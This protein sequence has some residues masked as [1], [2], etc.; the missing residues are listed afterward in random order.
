[1]ESLPFMDGVNSILKDRESW[2]NNSKYNSDH[3][4]TLF[5]VTME[6]SLSLFLGVKNQA[7]ERNKVKMQLAVGVLRRCSSGSLLGKSGENSGWTRLN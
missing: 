3:I 7:L 4:F 5:I 2:A 1:M 6:K